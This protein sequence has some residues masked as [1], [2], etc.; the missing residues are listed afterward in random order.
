LGRQAT[1]RELGSSPGCGAKTSM[2]IKY[3]HE[4]STGSVR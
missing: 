1:G 2:V 4:S 3:Q